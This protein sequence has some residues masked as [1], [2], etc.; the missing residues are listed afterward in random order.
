MTLDRTPVRKRQARGGT[1]TTTA[2]RVVPD[3][4][5]NCFELR[6]LIMDAKLWNPGHTPPPPR[7]V[8]E[9]GGGGVWDPKFCEPK[10]AQQDFPYWKFR[11]FPL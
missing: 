1:P 6:S 5:V 4:A 10:M 7:E 2:M 8:L 11:F 9:S 3:L